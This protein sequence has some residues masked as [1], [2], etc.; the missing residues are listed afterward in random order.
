[1]PIVYV[2]VSLGK[3]SNSKPVRIALYNDS[4]PEDI[5]RKFIRQQ[6]I[7]SEAYFN[8][9]VTMLYQAKDKAINNW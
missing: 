3:S 5:A 2:D 1:M 7:S 9:L 8:E 4:R 6:K